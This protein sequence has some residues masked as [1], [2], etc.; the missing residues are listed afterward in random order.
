MSVKYSVINSA[1]IIEGNRLLMTYGI[2][3]EN[4]N[5]EKISEFSDVS[6]NKAFT[7]KIAKLLNNA[8]VAPCHFY[9]VV[10]DELNR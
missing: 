1:V 8:E 5:G 7:E 9:E 3:A 2:A 4:E 10:I 6:V